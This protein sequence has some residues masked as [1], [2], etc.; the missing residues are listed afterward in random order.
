MNVVYTDAAAE[1]DHHDRY[2]EFFAADHPVLFHLS[3][4]NCSFYSYVP[5]GARL[6]DTPAVVGDLA[7]RGIDTTDR[8]LWEL[9]FITD[10]ECVTV[11]DR[12]PWDILV[13]APTPHG[14][15]DVTLDADAAVCA[16]TVDP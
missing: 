8:F 1:L 10:A 9:S 5:V 11:R 12:N 14:I 13:E 4:R 16:L 3:C 2:E 15:L 7:A 6:L